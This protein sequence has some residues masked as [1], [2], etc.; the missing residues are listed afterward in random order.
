[1]TYR[2]LPHSVTV[3]PSEIDGLGL[4]AKT[5]IS[6]DTELGISHVI[7]YGDVV[8]T[9]LGGFVNHSDEPNAEKVERGNYIL[10]ST[11]KDIM[12]GEEIT[13]KYSWYDP[14]LIYE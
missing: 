4:F 1:M 8:R 3:K 2:P 6:K 11:I 12:P 13:L 9:P 7:A 5:V 10:L 14:T